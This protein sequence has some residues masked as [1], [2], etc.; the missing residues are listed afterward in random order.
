MSDILGIKVCYAHAVIYG[1]GGGGGGIK[2]RVKFLFPIKMTYLHYTG[3]WL[4]FM[5]ILLFIWQ[6]FE[7]DVY[8]VHAVI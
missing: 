8:F 1:G 7:I 5:T 4:Y 2:K 3:L 6:H